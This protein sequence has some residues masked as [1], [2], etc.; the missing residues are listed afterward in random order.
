MGEYMNK[1]R[2]E[3]IRKEAIMLIKT[4]MTI[5]SLASIMKIS[6]STIHQDLHDKLKYIDLKLYSEVNKVFQN[7]IKTRHIIG[8]IKTREKYSKKRIEFML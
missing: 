2:E 5:R 7:H 4:K 8:G 6:K 3:R 1:E